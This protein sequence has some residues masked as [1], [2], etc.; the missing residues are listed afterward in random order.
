MCLRYG[1]QSPSVGVSQGAMVPPLP[2]LHFV[3]RRSFSRCGGSA[4]AAQKI[5]SPDGKEPAEA[6]VVGRF[7]R[8]GRPAAQASVCYVHSDGQLLRHLEQLLSQR[9]ELV[10]LG[11]AANRSFVA[12]V[13]N[14]ARSR[15]Q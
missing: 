9:Q 4:R 3:E 10:R 13:A 5:K 2:G 8:Y 14:G 11:A 1:G 15:A 12:F 7:R 6:P